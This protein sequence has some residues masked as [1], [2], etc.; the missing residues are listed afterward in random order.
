MKGILLSIKPE[1]C[2]SIVCGKKTIEVRKHVPKLKTP[3]KCYIYETATINKENLV[4]EVDGGIPSYYTKG[5][6]C[7]IGEFIC[8]KI[9]RYTASFGRSEY[10]ASLMDISDEEMITRSC[11]SRQQLNKYE[12]FPDSHR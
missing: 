11:L 5:C 2:D 3:F 7:V 6:G 12:N 9:Y 8:N 1:Y 10:N 4:A